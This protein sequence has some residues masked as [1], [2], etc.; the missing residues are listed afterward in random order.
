M[1][2]QDIQ[3]LYEPPGPEEYIELRIAAGMSARTPAAA[4][5]GLPNSLFVVTLREHGKLVGMGRVIG[6]GGCAYIVSDIVVHPSVQRRGLGRLIMADIE[7]YLDAHVEPGSF[8]SLIAD[9]PAD[10]LYRHFGFIETAPASIG[11]YRPS[12]PKN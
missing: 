12:R 9:T 5:A 1:E 2:N 4:R 11:M 10:A 8:V 6:D 3:V 7:R